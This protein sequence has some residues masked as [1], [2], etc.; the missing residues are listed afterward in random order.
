MSSEEEKY[1]FTDTVD[2]GLIEAPPPKPGAEQNGST[3]DLPVDEK[4]ED[5]TTI[6][7]G[8]LRADITRVERL[9]VLLYICLPVV[10]LAYLGTVF[11]CSQAERWFVFS[12]FVVV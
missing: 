4:N 7:T 2:L 8:P 9:K 5:V 12:L 11:F 1:A 6:L 10:V 3:R